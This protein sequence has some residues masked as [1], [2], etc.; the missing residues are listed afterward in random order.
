MSSPTGQKWLVWKRKYL[1]TTNIFVALIS[2]KHLICS[3]TLSFFATVFC[4]FSC[5]WLQLCFSTIGHDTYYPPLKNLC[6]GNEMVRS[7]LAAIF[8]AL[9]FPFPFWAAVI[10][11]GVTSYWRLVYTDRFQI[12]CPC[13][14]FSVFSHF[15][16]LKSVFWMMRHG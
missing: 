10:T 1:C 6:L 13:L 5:V 7:V 11:S 14:S 15:M 3:S 16:M 2:S 12:K 9:L 4:V 8:T